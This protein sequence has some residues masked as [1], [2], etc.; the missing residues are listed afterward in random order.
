[1]KNH[2]SAI[3]AT[4]VKRE[5]TVF[6]NLIKTHL[7]NLN[8]IFEVELANVLQQSCSSEAK[9]FLIEYD[10][11]LFD[12]QF[13]VCL[14]AVDIEVKLVGKVHWFLV[15]KA[16]VVPIEILE[17]ETFNPWI[18][19]SAVLESWVI[20]RWSVVGNNKLPAYLSHHD[21]HFVRNLATGT[22]TNWDNIMKEINGL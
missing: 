12:S 9:C 21:S 22:E 11:Q 14:Y 6:K 16:E 4:P 19:A 8:T 2:D 17:S 3:L 18:T 7:E 10:S 20:K 15:K 5:K 13:S 1:M